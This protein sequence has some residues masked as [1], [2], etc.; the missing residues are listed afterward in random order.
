M[1]DFP[2]DSGDMS[3]KSLHT[4]GELVLS[5]IKQM[6]EDSDAQMI[7]LSKE[8]SKVLLKGELPDETIDKIDTMNMDRQQFVN[9]TSI[10]VKYGSPKLVEWI[11]NNS[12][13][14]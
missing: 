6:R 8:V 13:K 7:R 1:F 9:F 2:L 5:V 10:S 14:R 12:Q 3:Y 11:I 4:D